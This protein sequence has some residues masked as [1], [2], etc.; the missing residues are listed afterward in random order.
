MA[1]GRITEVTVFVRHI[2]VQAEIG[3]YD[4]EKNRAQ[5]LIID[6]D[7]TVDSRTFE[8][9]RDTVNYEIV[10]NAA[11]EVA[12]SGHMMLV[13]TF[14]ERL[15]EKILAEPHA[16]RVRIRIEKPEALA[17]HAEGAGVDLVMERP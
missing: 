10:T 15:G 13:E 3:I 11:R 7:L 6:V 16:R 1:Q 2:R 8:H 17:P 5:P 4:H 14:A 12:S 9:L